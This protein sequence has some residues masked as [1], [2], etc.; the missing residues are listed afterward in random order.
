[1]K[2]NL[3]FIGNVS[4]GQ[5]ANLV[6]E[7][8]KEVEVKEKSIGTLVDW[9]TGDVK[10][11][12]SETK[13]S[14]KL[15]AANKGWVYRNNDVIAKE[16]AQIEFELYSVRVVGQEIVLNPISIHPLLDALDRF[17]NFTSSYD[18]FYNTQS[19]KKLA[20]NAYWFIEGGGQNISGIFLMPPE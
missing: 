19:H 6:K 14:S 3:P 18:G 15:L 11:L 4:L 1:M 8:I 16:I 13:I 9:I 5:D 10:G 7:I 17:N 12:T 2:F 20:G